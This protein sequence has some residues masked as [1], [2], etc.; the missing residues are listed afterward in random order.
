MKTINFS[1]FIENRISNIQASDSFAFAAA[2]GLGPWLCPLAPAIV[3]GYA[4]YVS[5]P[6][7]MA[8]F[9]AVTAVAV[10]I[11]LIVAGAVSS[12]NA[13]VS[14][15]WRP[16][17]LV[18]G[19][20]GLE[21]IGLWLMTVTFDVKV[22]GTVASLLTLIVYLS[23]ST[24][25]V[26]DTAKEEAKESAARKLTFQIEQ[27]TL[28]ADQKRLNEQC[29]AEHKR[30]MEQREAD[31]KHDEKM[32]RIGAKKVPQAVKETVKPVEETVKPFTL[33]D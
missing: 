21:I 28:N 15:G 20:I 6:I 8:E 1:E 4:L 31:L 19:Y 29:E 25:K 18:F 3:F 13:I 9:R 30:A 16:W 12:H 33:D 27:A 23:R 17:S 14:G 10:A 5:A 32:A 2:I 7:N 24:A 22:V 11:G 26:I